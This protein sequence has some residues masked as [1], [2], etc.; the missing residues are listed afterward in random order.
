MV[1]TILMLLSVVLVFLPPFWPQQLSFV[2]IPLALA[3]ALLFLWSASA[4]GPCSSASC[5]VTVTRT[6]P[7]AV[8]SPGRRTALTPPSPS[9]QCR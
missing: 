8:P 1:Q 9:S 6:A 2:G 5:R 7:A 4:L 3:G